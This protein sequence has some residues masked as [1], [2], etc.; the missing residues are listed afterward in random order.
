[1][2]DQPVSLAVATQDNMNTEQTT[3][4]I[5]AISGSQTHY[6]IVLAGEFIALLRPHTFC[7]NVLHVSVFIDWYKV[8]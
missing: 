7:L 5:H 1:M 6:P 8:G 2:S 3:M 4:Y